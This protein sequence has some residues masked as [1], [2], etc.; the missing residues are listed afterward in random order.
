MA[1]VSTLRFGAQTDE[2]TSL[3]R[4]VNMVRLGEAVT[5]PEIGRVTGL[6]RGVVSQRVDRAVEMGFLEDAEFAPSSGGRAPRTLRFR[7]ERGR[8]VV[9]A[10]GGLHI[11]VGVTD[12]DGE[13]RAEAHRDWDIARGPDETLTV[14]MTQSVPASALGS[15]VVLPIA[16]GSGMPDSSELRELRP[17]QI[18]TP[19][20]TM[21][22]TAQ[23]CQRLMRTRGRG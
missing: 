17:S 11:H 22:A 20:T 8:I 18:M 2:V 13:I 1:N 5:R 4:I 10:L 9:C 12:L 23:A 14:A 15:A 7:S 3:L 21:M 16:A 6:G 19:T